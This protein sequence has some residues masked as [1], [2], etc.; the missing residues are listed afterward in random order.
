MKFLSI[1]DMIA[2]SCFRM[3]KTPAIPKILPIPSE[4]SEQL[5][6][7]EVQLP[8]KHTIPTLPQL[9]VLCMSTFDK[10]R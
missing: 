8:D 10:V 6:I 9:S 2:A 3:H 1:K 4:G 5:I 7:L